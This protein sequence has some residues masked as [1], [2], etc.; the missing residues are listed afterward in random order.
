MF[1]LSTT[2]FASNY[3]SIIDD[4]YLFTLP[5]MESLN[6]EIEYIRGTYDFDI[7]F[8][9][10]DGDYAGTL[11]DFAE[12]H[13][14]IDQSRNGVV[15]TQDTYLREYYTIGRG[16]GVSVISDAAL[17]RIDEVIVPYLSDGDYFSAYDEYLDLMVVFLD[18]A[19]TG[20]P[21]IG[22]PTS[23]TDYAM[24]IGIGIIGGALVAFIVTK[25]MI[26]A[27]NTAKKQKL[28]A[29]YVRPGSFNLTQSYDRFLY[30]NTVRTAKPKEKSN[31]SS[32]G[33]GGGKY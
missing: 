31:S 25:S 30:E 14:V 28:A 4:A 11:E 21:Y 19:A 2:A 1:A 33:R 20:T 18:A 22:E 27:M 26:S 9:T 13:P 12:F 5:E 17:D 15:F 10:T 23:M 29:N 6:Q 16:T 32:G 8:I 3:P 24:Y 7:T